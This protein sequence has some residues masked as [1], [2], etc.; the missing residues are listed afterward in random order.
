MMMQTYGRTSSRGL[1][2]YAPPWSD[3]WVM[4]DAGMKD[5]R[6]MGIGAWL[7]DNPWLAIAAAGLGVFALSRRNKAGQ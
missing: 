1:T 7:M 3:A 4:K 6:D 5:E 2:G